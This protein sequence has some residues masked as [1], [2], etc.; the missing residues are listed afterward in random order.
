MIEAVQNDFR[1]RH[2]LPHEERRGITH[3]FLYFIL[4]Q[5]IRNQPECLP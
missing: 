2:A 4:I 5:G 3:A 1:D